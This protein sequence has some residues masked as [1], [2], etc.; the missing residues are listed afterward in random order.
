M[1]FLRRG[2]ILPHRLFSNCQHTKLNYKRIVRLYFLLKYSQRPYSNKNKNKK[3]GVNAIWFCEDSHIQSTGLPP[4]N[5][6]QRHHLAF[7]TNRSHPTMGNT[8]RHLVQIRLAY[9]DKMPAYTLFYSEDKLSWCPSQRAHRY[10][11]CTQSTMY[12]IGWIHIHARMGSDVKTLV[13]SE[14]RHIGTF[15]AA[16]GIRGRHPGSKN[17]ASRLARHCFH[18]QYDTRVLALI[19][20]IYAGNPTWLSDP[21]TLIRST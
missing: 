21:K 5:A 20:Y 15:V 16:K 7:K 19:S 12:Y 1:L 14:L 11:N 8:A 9:F 10:W 4:T 3:G 2:L 13:Q 6:R 17:T 18:D